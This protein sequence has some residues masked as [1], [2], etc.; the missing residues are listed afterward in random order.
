MIAMKNLS[1]NDLI[2]ISKQLVEKGFNEK[3]ST[4]AVLVTTSNY[5][6]GEREKVCN[7]AILLCEEV[8]Y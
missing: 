3:T 7:Q 1:P 2:E 6:K 4:A 8:D 5:I